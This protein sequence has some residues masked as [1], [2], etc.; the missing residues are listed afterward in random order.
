MGSEAS[1]HLQINPVTNEPFL[2]LSSPHENIII[3]PPRVGDDEHLLVLFSDIRI[4]AW[5]YPI[6]IPFT[7]AHAQAMLREAKD[8]ADALLNTKCSPNTGHTNSHPRFVGG[9]PV[10]CIREVRNDG[11]DVF[12]GYITVH[13]GVYEDVPDETKRRTIMEENEK[14]P[15]GDPSI[16]WSIRNVLLPDYH[17]RGIMTSVIGQM[18]HGWI[19]PRMNGR[20]IVAFTFASNIG[21]ERVLEKNGFVKV[22]V[23]E[24][25]VRG[26]GTKVNHMEWK[27]QIA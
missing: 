4:A 1:L 27:M 10:K 7:R 6:S 3:T 16:R 14:K 12:I 21:G 2:R 11:T 26:E 24:K 5:L 19:V 20:Y 25:M 23:F 8:E 17:G 9:C 13:R 15:V 18:V 22:A